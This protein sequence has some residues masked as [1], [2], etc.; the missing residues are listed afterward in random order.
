MYALIRN[1]MASKKELDE[2]YTLD[3]ALKLFALM[4]MKNDVEAGM[5]EDMKNN[6][7]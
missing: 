2:N 3:E 1:G 5:A 6:S 4:E 7:R